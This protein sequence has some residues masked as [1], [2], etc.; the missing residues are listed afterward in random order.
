M[1][2][3][4]KLASLAAFATYCLIFVGGLVRVSGAGLGCPDWPKCFGSWIPPLNISQIPPEIDPNLFNFTLAWIEYLNRLFGMTVGI[5]IAI[6]AFWALIKFTKKIRIVVPSV[7]AGILVAFEGWQGSQVISSELEPIIVSAHLVIA[8]IIA[9]LLL[10]VS[11]QAYYLIN[12]NTEKESSYPEKTK[13][14]V[15]I[16]WI[17]TI[18]QVIMGTQFREN[19]ERAITKF[20][21]FS[22]S[23]LLMQ[24]GMIKVIHP[25]FGIVV[26][27]LSYYISIMI[28]GK[29]KNPSS[30]NRQSAWAILGLVVISLFLGL[31][32][33]A[34]GINPVAQ[35]L[36]LWVSALMV[37]VVLISYT[38][39]GH[40]QEGR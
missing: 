19:I 37:G 13:T 20:P 14:Y 31:Q 2:S 36:H 39:L 25:L 32:M 3:F 22:E 17:I 23:E 6:V 4:M 30:L 12:P 9:C 40:K 24:V 15:G 35:V 29:S 18:I 33:I 11:Q 10:Y 8:F 21:L 1:K 16:L 28:L 26:A 7:L 34:F 27:V 5:L 38:A